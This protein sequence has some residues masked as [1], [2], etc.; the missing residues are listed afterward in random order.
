[1]ASWKD[2]PCIEGTG[3]RDKDGYTFTYRGKKKYR[4]HR[5]AYE[6]VHGPIPQGLEIDHL[7]RNSACIN[8]DH[9]EAVT[10]AE[11][12]RRMGP[13]SPGARLTQC[14]RGH[15]F[16]IDNTYFVGPRRWCRKCNAVRSRNYVQRKKLREEAL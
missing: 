14:K 9:L 13:H 5:F 2:Y 15:E 4:A 12:M 10:H 11:N 16:T 1:M 6:E 7:C 8:P 3:Y